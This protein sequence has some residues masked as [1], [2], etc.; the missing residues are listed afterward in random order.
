MG[1]L[2]EFI[3]GNFFLIIMVIAGL[4]GFLRNNKQEEEQ[5]PRERPVSRPAPRQPAPQRQSGERKSKE[6]N[7]VIA[8][9]IEDQQ[10]KQMDRLADRLHAHTSSNTD[11]RGAETLENP[12]RE[13]EKGLT[14]KQ[15]E[16]RSDIKRNLSKKGLINGIVMSEVLGPP[17]SKKPYRSVLTQRRK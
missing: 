13:P 16:T 7:V 14:K 3:F 11:F 8:E 17:R 5:S 4:M 1:N 15:E 6:K 10:N 2:I 12:L 9:S